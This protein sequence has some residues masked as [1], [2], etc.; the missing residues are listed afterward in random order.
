MKK[1]IAFLLVSVFLMS[2]CGKNET[3]EMNIDD[4]AKELA[5]AVDYDDELFLLEDEIARQLFDLEDDIEDIA[6]YLGSGSTSEM[7]AVFKTKGKYNTQKTYNEVLLFLRDLRD[8]YEDYLPKEVEKIDKFLLNKD[9]E[10]LVFCVTDD[11][12]TAQKIINKYFN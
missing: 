9:G 10:Y 1:I 11:D 2:A 5:T 7:V 3:L 8:E 6:M 4:F 12:K